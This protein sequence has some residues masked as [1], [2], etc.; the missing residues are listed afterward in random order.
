[1]CASLLH[2]GLY[3]FL[4]SAPY[5]AFYKGKSPA[6]A[7]RGKGGISWSSLTFPSF[8]HTHTFL[9]YY[10]CLQSRERRQVQV[11]FKR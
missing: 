6:V 5:G 11:T 10:S 2:I 9:L 7:S 3:S 1:M 4:Q 8:T